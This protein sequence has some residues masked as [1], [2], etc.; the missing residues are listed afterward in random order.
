MKK[1]KKA[2]AAEPDVEVPPVE[3]LNISSPVAAATPPVDLLGL[4]GEPE[5]PRAPEAVNNAP[6]E[7]TQPK[8]V[9]PPESGDGMGC[10]LSYVRSNGKMFVELSIIN[11][12]QAPIS[13]FALQ[14]NVN[15]VGLKLAGP[16]SVPN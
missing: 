3:T 4:G 13:G 6:D 1:T 9:L 8:I 12:S 15:I 5:P 16:L 2:P 10:A 14:L 7:K 11:K